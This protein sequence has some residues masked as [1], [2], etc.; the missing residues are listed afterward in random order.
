M[1]KTQKICFST[2][3]NLRAIPPLLLQII[4]KI[5]KPNKLLTQR[6]TN[7]IY[8]VESV[9]TSHTCIPVCF[10]NRTP[11]SQTSIENPKQGVCP[12][13]P[14]NPSPFPISPFFLLTSHRHLY[15]LRLNLCGVYEV[16]PHF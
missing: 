3:T 15:Y 7:P 8:Q 1:R 12:P 13:H 16:P 9:I 2:K 4:S 11:Y 10:L 5:V 6:K 14:L